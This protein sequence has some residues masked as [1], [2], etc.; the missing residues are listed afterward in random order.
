MKRRDFIALLGAGA[1]AS[2]QSAS[3]QQRGARV[4]VLVIGR[5]PAVKDFN[6][7]AELARLGYVESRRINYDIRAADGDLGRLPALARQLVAGNPDVLI[8]AGAIS[9]EALGAATRDIPIVITVMIDPIETGFSDSMSRPSRNV[10]GFTASSPTL[11][12]KRLE[13]LRELIPDLRRVAYLSAAP[14]SAYSILERNVRAAAAEWG[15]SIH[16]IPLSTEISVADGFALADREKVQGI[17][18]DNSPSNM[19][20]SVHIINECLVRDLPSIHPWAFEA[21]AGALMSYGPA[22]FENHAGAARYVDRILKGAKVAE[23]PFEEPTEIKL[24]VNLRTARSMRIAVPQTLLARA[25][26]VIE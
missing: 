4:G 22:A 25:D 12:A 7:A 15:I 5:A 10:T 13:L 11:S 17:L 21:H 23:L 20:L 3:A 26:E 6:I 19:R 14:G 1:A 16:S 2:L 8:G 24:V 18:V 9:A